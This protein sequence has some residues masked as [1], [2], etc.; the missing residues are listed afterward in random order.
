MKAYEYIKKWKEDY[1]DYRRTLGKYN[2]SVST[3]ANMQ[4]EIDE[5][6][7]KVTC[8]TEMFHRTPGGNWQKKPYESKETEIDAEFYMN[9]ITSIPM[10][11]DRVSYSY[12]KYGYI[13]TTLSCIS[14][15]TGE[16]KAKRTFTF[17]TV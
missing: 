10:F 3:M 16:T 7:Y 14:W 1:Y 4:T 13:P 17:T 6:K 5:G 12:T 8:L 2:V 11:N 9:V 15:G